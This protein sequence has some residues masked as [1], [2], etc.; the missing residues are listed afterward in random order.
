MTNPRQMDSCEHGGP[1]EA[2]FAC[3]SGSKF[4]H[5]KAPLSIAAA[6]LALVGLASPAFA[7]VQRAM[8]GDSDQTLRAMRDELERSKEKLR[9]GNLDRPYYIEYRLLD[10]DIRTIVASFGAIVNTNTVKNRFM[11]VDVR[12]GDYKVDN[13]N[14]VSAD[15]FQGFIGTTGTVGIDRD[16]E[17]LRQDLWLSTDQAYKGA[18]TNLAQKRAYMR[19]LAQPTNIDDFSREQPVTLVQPLPNIDWTSRNWEQEARAVSQAFRDYPALQDS[20]VTYHMIYATFYFLT[21]EGTQVRTTRTLAAIEA[22]A[23]TQADDGMR[24]HNF[25]ANYKLKPA[26]LPAVPAVRAELERI[27]KELVALRAAPPAP[28][29]TGPV[30]LEAPAAASLLAQLLGPSISGARPPLA[31]FQFFDQMIERMG[32]RSEW[33]GQLGDRVLPTNVSLVSDP[34]IREFNGQPLIGSYEVDDEGVKAQ[35][36][37]IVESGILRGFVMSR[38]PGPDFQQSNGHGRAALLG[39]SKALSSNVVLQASDT[40]SGADMRKKFLEAC[41]ADGRQWCLLVRQMDNPVLGVLRQQ[42]AADVFGLLASGVGGGD[43]LPLLVYKVSVADGK[44]ELVRGAWLNGLT[45][46][47]L[48]NLAAVGN[49]FAVY[50]YNQDARIAGTTLGAFGSAQGGIPSSVI[51]PS[52]LLSELQVRGARPTGARRPPI[53]PAPPLNAG[54]A[55]K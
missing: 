5:S 8:P 6:V 33:V 2:S 17:S 46:T 36:T 45:L 38:R 37:P 11:A 10:V 14:F 44:E 43:R 9:Q 31:S 52:I 50:N 26:D 47:K 30:L 35:R 16:Y 28:N 49:D 42:D 12:V 7:Q 29:Y 53:I 1:R 54:K 3:G 13:S 40:L 41:K 25:Y 23:E 21:S 22:G 24:L 39:E 15:A 4:P 51:A 19:N 48:R 27:S 34:T 55:E 18:L 32:G 20:R